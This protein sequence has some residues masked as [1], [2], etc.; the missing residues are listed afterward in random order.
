MPHMDVPVDHQ[1]FDLMEHRRMGGVVVAAKGAAGHDDA[2]RRL[3]RQHGADLH[4]RGMGAQ[5]LAAA[6]G[7]ARRQIEGIVLLPRRML[8]RNVER[9]EIV[10]I[11]FDMRAFG[12]GEAHLAE[13]RDQLVD[14]LADRMDAAVAVG[15][16]RQRHVDA[17]FG[18]PAQK[19]RLIEPR[20]GR[21]ERRFD[22]VAGDG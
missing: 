1:P 22:L 9:G 3:L 18:K 20:L 21:A 14:G 6:I 19:R 16:H 15:F 10:E 7:G 17:L 13:D 4:R 2:D 11:L 12:D 5:H 8:G